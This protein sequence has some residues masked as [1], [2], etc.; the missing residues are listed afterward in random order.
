MSPVAGTATPDVVV[1]ATCPG[2][3][4]GGF[5]DAGAHRVLY[6]GSH[7]RYSAAARWRTYA[8]GV[9]PFHRLKAWMKLDASA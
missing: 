4:A 2:G 6:S 8:V 5:P 3:L 7:D 9:T 1:P